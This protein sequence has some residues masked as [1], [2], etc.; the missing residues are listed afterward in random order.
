MYLGYVG[1]KLYFGI[2]TLGSWAVGSVLF[3]DYCKVKKW[4]TD[5]Y[6]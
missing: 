6:H 5:F 2:D 4:L 1:I 3:Y